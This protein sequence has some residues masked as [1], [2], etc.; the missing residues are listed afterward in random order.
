MNYVNYFNRAKETST[1]N[2]KEIRLAIF[3]QR[4]DGNEV[5]EQMIKNGMKANKT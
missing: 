5:H 3:R 2:V 4:Y 1:V